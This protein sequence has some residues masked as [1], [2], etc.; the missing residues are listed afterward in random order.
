MVGRVGRDPGVSL[1]EAV[2]LVLSRQALYK[3]QGVSGHPPG[4]LRVCPHPEVPDREQL[5]LGRDVL[6][7]GMQMEDIRVKLLNL[8]KGVGRWPEVREL[9]RLYTQLAELKAEME[10]EI[11]VLSLRRAFPR[12]CRLCPV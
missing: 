6:A 7:E 8:A 5:Q 1:T 9:A 2:D 11:E 3:V 12:H 4:I 10:E